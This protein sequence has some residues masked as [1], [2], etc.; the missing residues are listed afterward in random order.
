MKTD[1][2]RAV[3]MAL[4]AVALVLAPAMQFMPASA[5]PATVEITIATKDAAR[6]IGTFTPSTAT[7][8]QGDIVKWVNADKGTH[9]IISGQVK[10]RD[11]GAEFRSGDIRKG[12]S[13]SYTFTTPGTFDYFCKI[14]PVMTG[15][16]VIESAPPTLTLLPIVQQYSTGQA[17][18]V[19]GTTS[20]VSAMSVDIEVYNPSGQVYVLDSTQVAKDGSFSYTFTTAQSA[21]AHRVVAKYLGAT[22]VTTFQVVQNTSSSPLVSGVAVSAT[23]TGRTISIAVKNTLPSDIYRMSFT[24][25]DDVSSTRSPRDWTSEEDGRNAIFYTELRPI[26]EG[27]RTGFRVIADPPVTS[28][29]WVA[30]GE[31]GEVIATGGTTVRA[32]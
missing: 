4:C 16:V 31:S 20:L 1:P 10:D 32:R 29:S 28:F 11:A 22:S 9:S 27:K 14:H 23:S 21:G 25:P 7:A 17:V 15:T 3:L 6:N 19:R 30:F 12:S 24:L 5:A 2:K 18:T 13:F 8:K 26:Y